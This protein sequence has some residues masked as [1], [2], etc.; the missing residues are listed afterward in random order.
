M[1]NSFVNI[2]S[3]DKFHHKDKIHI[4]DFNGDGNTDILRQEYVRSDYRYWSIWNS[5]GKSLFDTGLDKKVIP[6]DNTVKIMLL[7]INQDGK[8]DILVK[9]PNYDH[10]GYFPQIKDYSMKLLLNVGNTFVN[11]MGLNNKNSQDFDF[12]VYGKFDSGLNKNVFVENTYLVNST[13]KPHYYTFCRGVK[14]NKI[15]K[16][17][18]AYEDEYVI[19][20]KSVKS[21]FNGG[22]NI[23]VDANILTSLPPEFEVASQI[24]G[25]LFNQQYTFGTP[26]I[27]KQGK[28][29]FGF[30]NIQIRDNI[31]GRI[32][33]NE[34]D[35]NTEYYVT[36]PK[37][38][39][40]KTTTGS[41]IS[42]SKNVYSFVKQQKAFHL[43]LQSQ[44]QKDYLSNVTVTKEYSR[45]DDSN[46]PQSIVTK[47][48]TSFTET[49]ELKYIKKGSWCANKIEKITT[50][51]SRAGV[52][53]DIRTQE[54]TY[55]GKGNLLTKT[56]DPNTSFAVST[57]YSNYDKYGNPGLITLK[58]GNESR[59]TSLAYS[60]TGRFITRKTNNLLN[61]TV[62]YNY[63]EGRS[64]LLSET[65]RLGT[66]IYEYDGFGRQI[67]TVSPDKVESVKLLK[68][69][70]TGSMAGSRFYEYTETSGQS[71]VTVWYDN[72]E[73]E[74]GQKYYGLGGKEIISSKEY[75]SKGQ[76]YRIS[77]PYFSGESATW[78]STNYYDSYGRLQSSVTPLGTTSYSYSGLTTQ[79]TSPN[80]TTTTVKNALGETVSQ[81]TNGKTVS[82]SYY[83]SGAVKT[84]TPEGGT[85][86]SMEYDLV[87]NRTKLTDPDAGVITTVYDAWGQLK[88]ETQSIHIGKSPVVTS[89]TY[90]KGLL[91][92]V[93]RQGEVTNYDYDSNNRLSEIRIDG[94]HTQQ[95]TYDHLDR[96]VKTV[97]NIKNEKSY[98]AE[99]SYDVFGRIKKE[100]YPDGYVINN[101][102]DSY[103]NLISVTDSYDNR[104]WQGLSAN[105]RGQLTKTKQ[106]NV[107]KTQFYDSRGLPSSI[108][109]AAIM[110]MAYTFNNKGNL[111]SRSDLLTG[112]K[113]DFT[114][115][116][117]NRLTAW[118]I[119]KDNVSQASNSIDYNPTT[120]TITTKSDV[121]FTFGYGEENGKPHALTS[122]SGKPDKIPN[123]AQTVTYTD[124]KKVKNISLGSK[125]LALDYGVDEQRRKGVFK[126]GSATFTRYYSGNYEEEVDSSGKVK[127]IHYISGGDGLAGIYINDD[128][129]NRFYSTYCDYQGSLLA[130]TDMNG[131][132]KERYAY[133]PWGNRRN[134]VLWKDPDVR[135]K[136]IVDRGYT[137][138]EHLDGFGLINMN[139]RVYDPLLGMF[140]SPDPYVQAP[141]NW[142]NYNRYGYCYGNPLL[143]TDPDGEWFWLIPIA[144]GA[145]IN[146][147]TN[148]ADFTWE[149]LG[150]FGTGALAGAST[151]L[152]L[153]GVGASV[154]PALTGG[155]TGAGNNLISQGFAGGNGNTWNGSNIN[156]GQVGISGASGAI[157]GY[158]G[159]KLA[160]KLTPY[161]SKYISNMF[162]GPV[163]QDMVTNGVVS[164]ATGFTVGAGWTALNGGSFEESMQG[165]WNSA[166]VGF[167]V[168][169]ATGS[170]AGWQRARVEDVSPW[171]GKPNEPSYVVTP[172]GVVLPKGAEIPNNLIDNP[173]FPGKGSYGIL[174]QNG[175]FQERVRIDQGTLPGFKGPNESHFHL[176][177]GK[178]IFDAKRWPWWK[179]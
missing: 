172:S 153:T 2:Y 29:F 14:F 83:A 76:L 4:G 53:D 69:A 146:W 105:A 169:G 137:L 22:T 89:Y 131:V 112:H 144:A 81:T 28:G 166:K 73:R 47:Y 32:T 102:Y 152:T 64:L 97:E 77:E 132:V 67:K 42:E 49:Q 128:G 38:T 35:M 110:N 158:V 104:I 103:G 108:S 62:T 74:L 123:S 21:P 114:Y 85:P 61:E 34:N 66:T 127:K 88:S 159:G 3:T 26:L 136:F 37:S 19:N 148:G 167:A 93:N 121:G 162:D 140:L 118:N 139:G 13:I 94:K 12:S 149:G 124:F 143:Y 68:W 33:V 60:S 109:A 57:V 52:P 55:D 125:S 41:L 135:T 44:T 51:K 72:M 79:V 98:T 107:E 155:I 48:G 43:Q 1:S 11:V 138:H 151:L 134:P 126:D 170:F 116:G 50:T 54:Y 99:T 177:G 9:Y 164:G 6:A 163:L 122:L 24:T 119:S 20:Y 8:T 16:I 10:S 71:P 63:D 7:D 75:N 84:A 25:K 142:L 176:N 56:E 133:D 179:K 5:T 17:K 59:S 80:T 129:N 58:A 154:V 39:L 147:I 95:F 92:K 30:K 36:Y 27:H 91:S 160:D 120:G 178:H 31:N 115:D 70:S 23:T 65:S 171:T 157:T 15:L 173:N 141:G 150:Y 111:I 175:I 96:I 161:V 113:E 168:G 165:G 40:T 86:I 100:T 156:W 46:N 145:I 106:G 18:N 174:N 117:M 90:S 87:G 101:S 78:A 130:L 45:Y 82:Y